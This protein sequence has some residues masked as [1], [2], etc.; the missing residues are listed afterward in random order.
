MQLIFVRHGQTN[1]NAANQ[2]L[3]HSDPALNE[4]GRQQI[5]HFTKIF[6]NHFRDS[7]TSFY[8]SDLRRT[9]ETAKMIGE[10]LNLK[11]PKLTSAIR[12]MHFGDWEL[13]TY[14]EIMESDSKRATSWIDN[15]FELA[16]PNGET[17]LALGERF[18]TWLEQLLEQ[19][20]EDEKILIVCH[21]GPIRWFRSKWLIGD[22]RQFWNHEGIKHGTGLVVEY[23]KGKREFSNANLIK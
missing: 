13:L 1:E 22:E 5:I 11:Q 2:Y 3:G 8:C 4:I 23:D 9:Q 7:I 18:D 12:E 19:S 14:E 15:P 10:S 16:P 20:A 21:G 6:P 17:L